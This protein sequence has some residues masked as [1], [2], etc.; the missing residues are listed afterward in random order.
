MF[1]VILLYGVFRLANPGIGAGECPSERATKDPENV[2]GGLR[3]S[4]G[5]GEA[6]RDQRQYTQDD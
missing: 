5:R 6:I 1:T 2:R 4:R 3:G